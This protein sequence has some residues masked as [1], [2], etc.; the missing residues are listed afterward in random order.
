MVHY[1]LIPQG[2]WGNV[3]SLA[4][5]NSL[6]NLT[7]ETKDIKGGVRANI[8]FSLQTMIPEDLGA[9]DRTILRPSPRFSSRMADSVAFDRGIWVLHLY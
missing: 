3:S 8:R 4:T 5:N 2:K 1:P 6:E 9:P 7:I